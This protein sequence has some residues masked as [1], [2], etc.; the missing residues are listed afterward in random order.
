MIY[1]VSS[2]SSFPCFLSVSWVISSFKG[3]AGK[4]NSRV[5]TGP[6]AF[7]ISF[8]AAVFFSIGHLIYFPFSKEELR[9]GRISERL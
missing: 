2:E 1:W 6:Y 9:F 3:A 4:V 5:K 8:K 7:G